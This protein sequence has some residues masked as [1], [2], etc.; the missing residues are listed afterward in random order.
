MSQ[1]GVSKEFLTDALSLKKEAVLLSSL[2]DACFNLDDRE[3]LEDFFV[4][5][6]KSDLSSEVRGLAF[7]CIGHLARI[8]SEVS[9]EKIFPFL[10]C[11][12]NDPIVGGRAQDA[13]D[14]IEIFASKK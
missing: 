5:V 12:I 14:D 13:I 3:W 4:S 11:E 6:A 8:Y 2:L 9:Y 1:I 10:M 7:S